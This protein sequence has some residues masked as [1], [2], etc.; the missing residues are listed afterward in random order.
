MRN[1]INPIVSM[2]AKI[3]RCFPLLA[4][5]HRYTR[6]STMAFVVTKPRCGVPGLSLPGFAILGAALLVSAPAL[7]DTCTPDRPDGEYQLVFEDNF[8]GMEL[9]RN[10]WNA[11]FLWGPGVVINNEL[12]YY[13]NENQFDYNP[14]RLADGTL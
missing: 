8:D 14:F 2:L 13:V 5:L 7:A 6:A 3:I 1:R 10:K 4:D 9:D 12:Q 11:E